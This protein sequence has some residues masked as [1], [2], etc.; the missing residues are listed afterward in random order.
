VAWL[1]HTV[2]IVF[3]IPWAL[4]VISEKGCS[5]SALWHAM[6]APYGSVSRF[7][8][9]TFWLGFQY[10]AFNY[11]YWSWLPLVSTSSAMTINQSQCIFVFV[12]SVLV[13]KEPFSAVRLV[14]CLLC[15]SGVLVLAYGDAKTEDSSDSSDGKQGTWQGDLMLLFPSACNAL[16]AVEWKRLVPGGEMRDSLVGL[17]SLAVWHLVLYS[18]GIPLTQYLGWDG[19]GGIMPVGD[20]WGALFANAGIAACF[21][22]FF[23]M[24]STLVGPVPIIV[25]GAVAMPL[26]Y[27]FDVFVRGLEFSAISL[28]GALVVFFA[29]ILLNVVE[30]R[31]ANALRSANAAGV[32][33]ALLP[34]GSAA[35]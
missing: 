21:N 10:I 20:Q 2:L 30:R 1:N 35:R 14:L 9:V 13:L 23:M 5:C 7:I 19:P 31:E 33:E 34:S 32:R 17:G 12:F 11:A 29:F 4:I 24:G 27:L 15:F 26:T 6:V 28:L 18:W 8:G 3:L 22:F 16:Y 25:G